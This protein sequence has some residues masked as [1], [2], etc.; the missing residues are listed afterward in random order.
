MVNPRN[1]CRECRE[2]DK[3]ADGCGQVFSKTYS[4]ALGEVKKACDVQGCHSHL[5]GHADTS[6]WADLILKRSTPVA[7][8]SF[9]DESPYSFVRVRPGGL[10][11]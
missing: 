9:L 7:N 10:A 2:D 4:A 6:P 5:A 8:V 3:D 11:T 1:C